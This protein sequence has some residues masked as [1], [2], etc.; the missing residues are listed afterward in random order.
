M[1]SG[2]MAFRTSSGS[3][4]PALS[5]GTRVTSHPRFSTYSSVSKTA[6]CSIVDVMRCCPFFFRA[7][8]GAGDGPVVGLG[9]AAREVDLVGLGADHGRYRIAS[10]LNA[11]RGGET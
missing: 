2:R 3:T 4:K 8:D 10:L 9:A 1:V 11:A 7:S 5:T 6:W